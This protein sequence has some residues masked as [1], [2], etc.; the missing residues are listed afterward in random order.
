MSSN[1]SELVPITKVFKIIDSCI[2][3]NQLKTCKELANIYTNLVRKKGVIN[4]GDVKETLDIKIL[5][6]EIELE[7][8]ERFI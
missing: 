6:K 2:N 7:Y 3:S 4:F 5:E 8:I 1:N